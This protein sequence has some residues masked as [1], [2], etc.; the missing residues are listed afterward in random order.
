MADT[1]RPDFADLRRRDRV[2]YLALFWALTLILLPVSLLGRLLP[3]SLR[4]LPS[5]GRGFVCDAREAASTLAA[6]ALMR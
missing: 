1:A 4:P 5:T 6:F 2:E 3:R